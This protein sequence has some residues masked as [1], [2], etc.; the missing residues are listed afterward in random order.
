MLKQFIVGILSSAAAHRLFPPPENDGKSRGGSCVLRLLSTIIVLVLLIALLCWAIGYGLVVI[1]NYALLTLYA[2]LKYLATNVFI[3]LD[4][5][6]HPGFDVP[7][8]AAWAFWGLVGGSAIQGC[9]EMLG[10]GRK[11][12]GAMAVLGPIL[13][14]VFNGI[15]K[16][17]NIPEPPGIKTTTATEQKT[18]GS[19]TEPIKKTK[20]TPTTTEQ[21]T[22]QTT[23]KSVTRLDPVPVTTTKQRTETT[24]NTVQ[25]PPVT[26]SAPPSMVS[27]PAGEFQ[28]GSDENTDEQPVH[29]VYTDAF[30]MDKYEVTNAQYKTFVNANPQ[31]RKDRISST[32]HDGDYLKHWSGNN[33]PSGKG[34]HP[35]TYVSWYAAM[36]YAKWAGKRLPTEAEWEKAARGGLIGKKYPWGDSIGSSRANY[37]KNVGDTTSVGQYAP[38]A[39]SLYDMAGNVAEWCL[40]AYDQDF[41]AN[42]SHQNPISDANAL[43]VTTNFSKISSAPRVLRG[44]SWSQLSQNVRVAD[45]MRGDPKS[46]YFGFGFRCVQ[47]VTPT[48]PQ[49]TKTDTKQKTTTQRTPVQTTDTPNAAPKAHISKVWVD[50][51]Q[52]QNSVNGMRIHVEFNVHNFKDGSG[53]VATY[54][55]KRDGDRLKDTN[56][57]YNTADGYVSTWGKF[58]PKY[59]ASVYEDFKLFIPYQELHIARGKHNLKLQIRIFK[60]NN[61]GFWDALSDVSDWVHFTYSR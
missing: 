29:T 51:N 14:L 10:R 15:I 32:Y 41:Y 12:M 21:T 23:G 55:F 8:A 47:A 45:R 11:G 48:T 2:G 54:F 19:K 26:P 61:S 18:S 22:T 17:F 40:D 43:S 58:Q 36:A 34:N 20:P 57:N 7:P 9:R 1:P 52:Y 3:G 24:P 28:M 33:Y 37:N 49:T 60:Y 4:K 46:S 27:I 50:H 42:A 39:Y 35:V 5:L 44:G 56:D 25:E 59:A 30:Y 31:W 53:L 13:L 38:N 6:F 16:D